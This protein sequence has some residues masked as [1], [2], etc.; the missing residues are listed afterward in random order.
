MAYTVHTGGPPNRGIGRQKSNR[1]RLV[2]R[3][4]SS[5]L[6]QEASRFVFNDAFGRSGEENGQQNS[7]AM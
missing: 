3:K 6:P 1:A 5:G 2:P 7:V 4:Q